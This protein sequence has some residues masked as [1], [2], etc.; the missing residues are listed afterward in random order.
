MNTI[1]H[2][3]GF[4]IALFAT[5][6][7][8]QNCPHEKTKTVPMTAQVV[9]SVSC[10]GVTFQLPGVTVQIPPDTC[11]LI[12]ITPQHEVAEPSSNET[13]VQRQSLEPVV[14]IRSDCSRTYFLI[15]TL[16][17]QCITHPPANIGHVMRLTTVGCEPSSTRS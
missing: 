1:F 16:N 13:R 5:T 11:P 4:C 2:A 9:G 14:L 12:V 15:F 10:A 8:A 17:T 7:A 3:F 6:A